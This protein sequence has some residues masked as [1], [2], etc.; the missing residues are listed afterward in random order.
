MLAFSRTGDRY[1]EGTVN[2]I[3]TEK[4][5]SSQ[6]SSYYSED[7]GGSDTTSTAYPF[8]VALNDTDGL[9]LGQHL[10]LEPD[11]GQTEEKDGL[12]LPAYY[13]VISEGGH[14]RVWA[15]SSRNT[16]ELRRVELGEYDDR[17]QQYEVAAGLDTDDYITVP[18]SGLQE[19]LPVSYI[20]YSG[21]GSEEEWGNSPDETED[22]AWP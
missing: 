15:A 21:E 14:A 11:M 18:V 19:G 17:L 6:Q 20:D 5:D 9:M 12:W 22:A 1:W 8:Y 13:F 7:S 3:V 2:E 4:G 10:Y 16:L